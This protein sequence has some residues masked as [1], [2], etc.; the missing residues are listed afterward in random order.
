VAWA[1]LPAVIVTAA[2]FAFGADCP[3]TDLERFLRHQA[4]VPAYRGG[5]VAHY[6]LP[7]VPDGLRAVGVPVFVVALTAVAYT[8][9]V[10]RRRHVGSDPALTRAAMTA[11]RR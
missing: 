9:Y 1:H 8:G 2:L 7:G 4:G 11:G 6:L 5:F 3:L 10:A